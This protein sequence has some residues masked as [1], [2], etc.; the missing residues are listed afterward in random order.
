MMTQLALDTRRLEPESPRDL[1]A[2]AIT[3]IDGNRAAFALMVEYAHQDASRYGIVRV[4]RYIEDIRMSP[5]VKR[6]DGGVVKLKN[7][8]SAPLGRIIAAWYPDLAPFV[9]LAA[10]KCDG[11][12]VPPKPSW[13][14]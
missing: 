12:I 13:V 4:K 10:S 11:V 5:L 2:S 8:L 14:K 9:P 6:P 3:W 7:A 1:M